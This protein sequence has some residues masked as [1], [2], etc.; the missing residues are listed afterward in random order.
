MFMKKVISLFAFAAMLV[1]ATPALAS[2]T[3]INKGNNNPQVVAFYTSGDHGIVG[4]S[5]TH[6]GS[7]L[8]MQAGNSGNFQQWFTGTSTEGVTEEGDHSLWKNVGNSTS[9]PSGSDLVVNAY[10][11]W[12][13]YLQPGANYC[14]RTNDFNVHPNN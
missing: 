14:V 5:A 13:D 1:F 12:G 3:N 9:C 7:D 6:T 11:A 10:P 2:P 4:E 8:I